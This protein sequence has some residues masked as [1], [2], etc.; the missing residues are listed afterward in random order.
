MIDQLIQQ[1]LSPPLVIWIGLG[2]AT[3]LA[4]WAVI[5]IR[6]GFKPG[7][8]LLLVP[9]QP[10]RRVPWQFGDVLA[11]LAFYVLVQ[12]VVAQV[13]IGVFDL[14]VPGASAPSPEA[15]SSEEGLKAAHPLVVL[16]HGNRNL[17]TFL[18]CAFSAVV[19]APIVEEFL[20]RLLLQG[21]LEAAERR[22]R[23]WLP[24]LRALA[25][26]LVPVLITSSMF[27]IVHYRVPSEP[28]NARYLTYM[29]AIGSICSLL[30]LALAVL[31]LRFRSG[32][33][34]AD[35]G[36]VPAKLWADVRLGLWS[37]L[38][39]VGP[40]YLLQILLARLLPKNFVPDPITMFFFAAVLGMLYYRTHRIVPSIVVH[41]SLNAV[42]LCM[43]WMLP[44]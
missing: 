43:V 24:G 26:G 21:W 32:A 25:P 35:L 36:F 38:A 28:G 23:P 8:A 31:L 18:F 20:F 19:V 2:S 9:Y 14:E 1:L 41:M 37:F 17:A 15:A 16:L 6:S 34:L 13:A 42:S 29:L 10:R 39:V 4:T 27:A 33:T 30:T 7:R 3:F 11:V 22:F 44:S 12:G 5:A 40:I